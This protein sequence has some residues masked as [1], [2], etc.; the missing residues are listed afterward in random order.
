MANRKGRENGH[1]CT[2]NSI[3]QRVRNKQVGHQKSKRKI[4]NK[5]RECK[6]KPDKKRMEKKDGKQKHARKMGA[7]VHK[8]VS[9]ER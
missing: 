5:N 7:C 1:I 3:S 4:S 9:H 2:Q 6:G 8:T